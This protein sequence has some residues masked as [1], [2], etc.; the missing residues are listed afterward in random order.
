[1]ERRMRKILVTLI[2]SAFVCSII[3]GGTWF[4]VRQKYPKIIKSLPDPFLLNNGSRVSTLEEWEVR[5]D[6]IITLLLSIE[7]GTIPNRPDSIVTTEIQQEQLSN[8][9]KKTVIL[10]L[11]PFNSTPSLIVNMTI[12]VYIPNCS[13]PYPTILKVGS[14]GS[15]SQ[16]PIADTILNRGYLYVCYNHT[17]LDPDTEGYDVVGAIQAIYPSYSFGS[18]GV[19]AWGASCVVDYLIG[20][21]WV[22]TPEGKPNTDPDMLII[23]GHSRRGKTA[24]LA[25]A[26]D[27][28]FAMVVP[29]DSGCGGTGSFLVQGSFSETLRIITSDKTYRSWFKGD[30]DK[31]AGKEKYLPFDQHFLCS[32]VAPRLL[33]STNALH[34]FWANPSGTQAI[35]KATEL[36]Y[37]FLGKIENNALHYRKG[38]HG[39]LQGDFLVLLDFA[40][41]ML[42]GKEIT[43]DFY[44]TPYT[45]DIPIDFTIP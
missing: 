26:L 29:N 8:G 31:Y 5:R 11:F 7:Y 22:E 27:K 1:M 2:L 6:E 43:G 44:M 32:L 41:K 28:R 25:G 18:L 45:Y 23:T 14:D 42:V 9:T 33:L 16:V 3:S 10:S 20:E 19:W 34:D 12:W 17:D 37:E 38:R 30:F 4:L 39:F 21:S 24:L 13:G 15:G 40:D 35:Y 36:V